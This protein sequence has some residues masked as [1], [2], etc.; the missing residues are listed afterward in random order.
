MGGGSMG[1]GS[2]GG[3]SGVASAG[4]GSSSTSEA[5]VDLDE[6]DH[7]ESH[8]DHGEA[9]GEEVQ[10]H[11]LSFVIASLQSPR[12]CR[13]PPSVRGAGG[14]GPAW[15]RGESL[16]P[17]RRR[18]R[19]DVASS[20]AG[21]SSDPPTPTSPWSPEGLAARLPDDLGEFECE[22][23]GEVT[24]LPPPPRW[25]PDAAPNPAG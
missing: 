11:Q 16:T 8:A 4:G 5:G 22:Y 3:G 20:A 7:G 6:R 19:T 17:P 14:R 10:D 13:S 18:R 21:V 25:G 24:V 2:M 23:G 9:Y 15:M 12:R 1:S